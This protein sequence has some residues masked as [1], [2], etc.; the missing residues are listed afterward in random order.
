MV[1]AFGWIDSQ[2]IA[3]IPFALS[4]SKCRSF[5][6]ARPKKSGTSTSSVQTG[7]NGEFRSATAKVIGGFPTRIMM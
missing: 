3:V 2:Q 5:L 7:E 1:A 6:L 4:Q